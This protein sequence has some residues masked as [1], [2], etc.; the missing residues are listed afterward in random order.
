MPVSGAHARLPKDGP[1]GSLVGYDRDF[2][3]RNPNFALQF[4]FQSL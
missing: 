4:H 2:S 1:E 3:A